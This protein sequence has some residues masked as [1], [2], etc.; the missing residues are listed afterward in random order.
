MRAGQLVQLL[1]C[2]GI[3]DAFRYGIVDVVD[4]AVHISKLLFH[5]S[6]GRGR[7]RLL[8]GLNDGG[9]NTFHLFTGETMV[10]NKIDHSILQVLL[11]DGL[12]I[13]AGA[14]LF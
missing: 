6:K 9:S 3:P 13:A 8:L 12:L 10:E 11:A 1:L 4:F 2:G 14:A 5:L 7:H